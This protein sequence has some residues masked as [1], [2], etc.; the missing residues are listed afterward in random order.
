MNENST[1]CY[2]VISDILWIFGLMK[3]YCPAALFLT[4]VE[5]IMRVLK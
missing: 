1:K 3:K 4:A 2:G 5:I